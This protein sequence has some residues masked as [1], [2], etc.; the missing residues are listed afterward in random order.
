M[1]SIKKFLSMSTDAEQTLMHVVRLLVEGIGR[2]VVAGDAADAARFHKSIEEA[3]ESLQGNIASAELLVRVGSVVQALED[4]TGRTTREQ[5]MQTAELQHM[6]KMLTA[7]VSA[8]SAASNTSVSRLGEIEQ[9]V[10]KVSA[11][12]DVRTIKARLADCLSD[13]RKEADRQQ[14]ETGATIEELTRGLDEARKHSV[15]VVSGAVQDNVTGLRARA[16]AEAA[17]AE[18][19]RPGGQTFVTV[20][21]LDRLQ[22]VNRRFG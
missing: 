11:L 5:Q 8:V 18:P 3:S 7:T 19:T 21:V 9:Q 16:D 6:V 17:L 15:N 4:H 12:D 1:I 14:K 20:L 22:A 10:A 13:I 2:H